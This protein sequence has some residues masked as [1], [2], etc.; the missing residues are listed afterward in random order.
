MRSSTRCQ[1][2][3]TLKAFS[4]YWALRGRLKA[5][6]P[7]PP[8]APKSGQTFV[9]Y[10]YSRS[11]LRLLLNAVPRCQRMSSCVMSGATFRT[12]LLFLYGTGMRLGEALRLRLIDVDLC[13]GLVTIRGTKFYKSRLV[14]LGR[15][16]RKLLQQYLDMPARQ[17]QRY[18]PLFQTTSCNP[19]RLQVVTS[20]SFACDG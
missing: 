11:D 8:R 1:K 4:Q 16:V 12:L 19:I 20:V 9:P 10:I 6:L 13:V 5:P 14:P 15:D 3:G 7:L 18:R 17:N 2:R